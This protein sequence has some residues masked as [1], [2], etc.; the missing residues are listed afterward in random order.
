MN[1]RP[2]YVP[3]RSSV[4]HMSRYQYN[5]LVYEIK[6][7]NGLYGYHPQVKRVPMNVPR[8]TLMSRIKI[9]LSTPPLIKSMCRSLFKF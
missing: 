2:V 3:T 7:R 5:S 1:K 9:S 8:S 6:R 4:P